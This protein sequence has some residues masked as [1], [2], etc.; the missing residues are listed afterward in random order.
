MLT[1]FWL[2]DIKKLYQTAGMYFLAQ[3]TLLLG[4]KK[5]KLR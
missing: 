1:G 2:K 4:F 3:T 5:E